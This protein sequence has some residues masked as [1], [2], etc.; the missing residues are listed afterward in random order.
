MRPPGP[1]CTGRWG[2]GEMG[3]WGDGAAR[4]LG[5]KRA[6]PTPLVPRLGRERTHRAS[7]LVAL[8]LLRR[9][10]TVNQPQIDGKLQ[11]PRCP[12][13]WPR[14][15]RLLTRPAQAHTRRPTGFVEAK[16]K[17][18]SLGS[19]TQR[20]FMSFFVPKYSVGRH[21]TSTQVQVLFLQEF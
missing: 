9:K 5:R 17:T 4:G 2:D 6:I 15:P 8:A 1:T 19:D 14:A 16:C 3:R 21:P 18:K 12:G 20:R 7:K 13:K 11:T 10:S